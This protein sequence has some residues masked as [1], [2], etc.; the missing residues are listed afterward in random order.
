MLMLQERG[1][2]VTAVA[3][4]AAAFRALRKRVPDVLVSDI[5]MPG[6]DGHAF[7]RKLR[8][9]GVGEGAQVP[10][11]ALTAYATVA[12]AAQVLA[13]GFDR[14]VSKPV[15]PSEIVAVIASLAARRAVPDAAVWQTGPPTR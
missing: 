10:A 9:L 8:T 6:Q 5:G 7:I 1:A 14:H 3:S 4:V 11:V 2:D 15:V 12:D 13:S